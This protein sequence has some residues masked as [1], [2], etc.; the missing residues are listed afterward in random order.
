VV[1]I[2]LGTM[3]DSAA[4][5]SETDMLA[6]L[7][8]GKL[9]VWFYPNVLF[10]DRDLV[11]QTKMTKDAS[12]LGKNPHILHFHGTQVTVRRSDGTNLAVAVSPY[13][14]KL[15]ALIKQLLWEDAIRLCR[16]V[17]DKTLWACLAVM[18]LAD[19]ELS[20]AELAF[21][22]I[23]QVHKLQYVLMIK[24]IPT[25]E[26][27][28]A[29]LL[30][31]RRRPEEAEAILLGAKLIYR[32]ID[33]NMRL[34]RWDR[35]LEIAKHHQS[36]SQTF[37]DIVVAMRERY[38]KGMGREEQEGSPFLAFRDNIKIDWDAI[39]NKIKQEHDKEARRPGAGPYQDKQY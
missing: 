34:F 24:D 36:E 7:V 1:P 39:R 23:D 9:M 12:D 21:A 8:D 27:R 37:I 28:N 33:M 38:L 26:G 2:K 20:T 17:K 18:A 11:N 22:A 13:P 14:I 29:E 16:Y 31:W 15:Y 10:I 6:A 25:V 3:C 32:A 5:N 19:K 4:W 30:L 35:A